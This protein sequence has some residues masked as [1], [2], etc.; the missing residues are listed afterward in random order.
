MDNGIETLESIFSDVNAS[1]FEKV[2]NFRD[3]FGLQELVIYFF[4]YFLKHRQGKLLQFWRTIIAFDV[5][6]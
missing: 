4:G 6:R 3:D 1:V 5:E 2:D